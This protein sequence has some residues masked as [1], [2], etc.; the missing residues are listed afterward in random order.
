MFKCVQCS[1]SS[2]KNYNFKRHQRL[3]HYSEQCGRGIKRKHYPIQYGLG[4][5]KDTEEDTDS[6]NSDDTD[7]EDLEKVEETPRIDKV[8]PEDNTN[9]NFSDIADE[10]HDNLIN[11]EILRDEYLRAIPQLKK[12]KGK[13]LKTA[14]HY[15]A[16]IQTNV[17]L[18]T[19]GLEDDSE[20][21]DE[22]SDGDEEDSDNVISDEEKFTDE[23]DKDTEGDESE[24]EQSEC[25]DD[26]ID[27]DESDTDEGDKDSEGDE[28]DT[29]ESDKDTE[30]EESDDESND[31][32]DL[33]DTEEESREKSNEEYLDFVYEADNFITKKNKEFLKKKVKKMKTFY[34]GFYNKEDNEDPENLVEIVKDALVIKDKVEE[35]GVGYLKFCSVKQIKSMCLAAK[36]LKSSFESNP[37]IQNNYADHY[38]K[39]IK[40]VGPHVDKLM[41]SNISI[42]MKRNILQKGEVC[43]RI[44]FTLLDANIPLTNS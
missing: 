2:S 5:E 39:F 18:M 8:T 42:H 6:V 36:I 14:L 33:K 7:M 32:D 13:K 11:L 24:D 21:M 22:E 44:L 23:S 16:V 43:K 1:Y 41:D 10:I 30:G 17:A 28:S 9:R 4:V 29:D 35:D 15:L 38:R 3:N 31:E 20:D 27:T 25:E 26:E 37:L 40:M 19:V 12:L 34:K